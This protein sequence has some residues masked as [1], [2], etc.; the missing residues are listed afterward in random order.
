ME[1][2]HAMITGSV[3]LIEP[4]SD[5]EVL[6]ALEGF[7]EVTFHAKSNSGTELV[8]NFEA[9]DPKALEDLCERLKKRIH[10]IIDVTHIYVNF[11]EEVAKLSS[12]END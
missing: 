4:D 6:Q 5:Q 8:V 2:L 7:P 1:A 9:D 12:G 10:P 3:I 11:E